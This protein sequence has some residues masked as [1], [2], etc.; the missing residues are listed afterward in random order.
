MKRLFIISGPNGAGKT[1][2][3]FTLLPE[4]LIFSTYLNQLLM[5]GC[6]ST[7]QESHTKS[8]QEK[9]AVG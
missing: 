3:S 9:I 2:A 8:L 6:L 4:L 7:T 5:N 1:T